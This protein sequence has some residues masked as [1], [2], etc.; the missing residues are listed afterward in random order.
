MG[1]G[2]ALTDFYLLRLETAEE[3]SLCSASFWKKSLAPE[4]E[5][6]RGGWVGVEDALWWNPPWVPACLR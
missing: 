1:A 5:R 2:G 3:E 6:G 4:R